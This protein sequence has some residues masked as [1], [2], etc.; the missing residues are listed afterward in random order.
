MPIA[1][2]HWSSSA[3]VRSQAIKA[4]TITARQSTE[5]ASWLNGFQLWVHD[6]PTFAGA[7]NRM[8]GTQCNATYFPSKMSLQPGFTAT[9]PCIP[10]DGLSFITGAP[11]IGRYVSLMAVQNRSFAVVEMQVTSANLVLASYNKPCKLSSTYNPFKCNNAFDGV[12]DN[13]AHSN[14]DL[15]NFITVDLGLSTAVRMVQIHNRK[16]CC[17][18]RLNNFDFYVGDSPNYRQNTHC[19]VNLMPTQTP[20]LCRVIWADGRRPAAPRRHRA[21]RR[22]RAG[23]HRLRRRSDLRRRQGHSRR[24]GP[25]PALQR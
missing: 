7:D 2:T 8:W 4:V 6:M 5:W 21:H 16:D 13:F 17:Q 23:L 10:A 1:S 9:V 19:P 22:G 12:Y 3:P 24:H 18:S 20:R 14:G 11:A 15:D 25:K